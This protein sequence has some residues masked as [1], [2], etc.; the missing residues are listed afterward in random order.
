MTSSSFYP[1]QRTPDLPSVTLDDFDPD[2]PTS[3]ATIR[4]PQLSSTGSPRLPPPS[5]RTTFL[6]L[7]NSPGQQSTTST[8]NSTPNV[9]RPGSPLPQFFTPFNPSSCSSETESE[10]NSPLLS[11]RP[12]SGTWRTQDRRWWEFTQQRRRR[13]GRWWR[14]LKKW[15]RRIFRHPLVP[16]QPLTIVRGGFPDFD[17]IAHCFP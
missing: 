14:F 5:P 8:A 7:P 3:E 4:L 6:F 1:H 15:T 16:K 9:S 11:R 12:T 13:D 2:S 17:G 10:D